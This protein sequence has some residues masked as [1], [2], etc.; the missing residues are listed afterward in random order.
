MLDCAKMV[1]AWEWHKK[2]MPGLGFLGYRR[3]R[4]SMK[5]HKKNIYNKKEI[6]KIFK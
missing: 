5:I 4:V 1:T 3:Y 6:I 2:V